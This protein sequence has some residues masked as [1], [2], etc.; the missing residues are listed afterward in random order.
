MY[1]N[2]IDGRSGDAGSMVHEW[3]LRG[4]YAAVTYAVVLLVLAFTVSAQNSGFMLR[5]MFNALEAFVMSGCKFA[6]GLSAFSVHMHLSPT[7]RAMAGPW[8][9][10]L[11]GSKFAMALGQL[12]MAFGYLRVALTSATCE[13]L[14]LFTWSCLIGVVF[15]SLAGF[16]LFRV[17]YR[18]VRRVGDR[19]VFSRI[20]GCW[21]SALVAST[22][23]VGIG[24]WWCGA[25][26]LI[27]AD[28]GVA[29]MPIILG[30]TACCQLIAGMSML[31]ANERIRAFFNCPEGKAKFAE[32]AE[33]IGAD[34]STT[35][36]LRTRIARNLGDFEG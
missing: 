11:S 12:L 34:C 25:M 33:R 17:Y 8:V 14:S 20:V 10:I 15:Q 24:L 9:L 13:A 21:W 29:G 35:S 3:I 18:T 30:V 6:V 1:G 26:M 7:S 28:S 4:G 31:G 16:S 27:D 2:L 19:E 5:I 36:E 22:F 32:L 23:G